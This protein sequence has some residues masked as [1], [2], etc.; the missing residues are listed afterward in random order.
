M[1]CSFVLPIITPP[2]IDCDCTKGYQYPI[3]TNNQA[4]AQTGYRHFFQPDYKTVH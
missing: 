1:A 3:G 2:E 4:T